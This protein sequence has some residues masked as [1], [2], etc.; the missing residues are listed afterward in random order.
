MPVIK[1]NLVIFSIHSFPMQLRM[2]EN[3]S[4][5]VCW[6]S[7]EQAPRIDCLVPLQTGESIRKE[8]SDGAISEQEAMDRLLLLLAPRDAWAL[9]KDATGV[10]SPQFSYPALVHLFDP[11]CTC[12]MMWARPGKKTQINSR[13]F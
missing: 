2:L 4:Y 7:F 10:V 3:L 9:Y 13:R 5:F 11:T 12:Y 6:P 8:L 1:P